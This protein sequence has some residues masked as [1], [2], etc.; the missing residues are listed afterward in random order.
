ML[1]FTAPYSPM[2]IKSA[3]ITGPFKSTPGEAVINLILTIDA[4]GSLKK[5]L[6]ERDEWIPSLP[7]S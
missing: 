4:L 5:R 1:T 3:S 7:R 2:T 6:Q